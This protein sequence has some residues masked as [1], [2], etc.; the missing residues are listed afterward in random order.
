MEQSVWFY[1]LGSAGIATLLTTLVNSLGEWVKLGLASRS[2]RITSQRDAVS[3]FLATVRS[4]QNGYLSFVEGTEREN[5]QRRELGHQEKDDD[6]YL[7]LE[8]MK[9]NI[10]HSWELMDITL[11]DPHLR[12]ASEKVGAAVL[13]PSNDLRPGIRR[14]PKA[15]AVSFSEFE[16]AL[17]DLRKA[18]ATLGAKPPVRDRAARLSGR[19]TGSVP[20][21]DE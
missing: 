16:A 20:V 11:M 19:R 7:E 5:R 21:E 18:T 12:A 14:A 10:R 3:R 13:D 8:Q 1:V 2:S 9:L 17:L 6:Y 15:A 4:E